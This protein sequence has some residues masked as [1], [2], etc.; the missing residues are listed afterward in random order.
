MML[1]SVLALAAIAQVLSSNTNECLRLAPS[2]ATNCAGGATP[3]LLGPCCLSL[4]SF[5]RG[6]C[7]CNKLTPKASLYAP[8]DITTCKLAEPPCV[9]YETR[10]YSG[11]TCAFSD[12]D[13]DFGRVGSIG[14]F[15]G[16]IGAYSTQPAT[17]CFDYKAFDQTIRGIFAKDG[18][19]A[20]AYGTGFF[21]GPALI[22]YI[23]GGIPALTKGL[24]AVLPTP[25]P[26]QSSE[27]ISISPGGSTIVFGQGAAASYV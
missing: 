13:I 1:Y 16:T 19:I 4:G 20:V 10:T 9:N 24:F 2:V 18:R 14:S 17:Q 7:H 12:M 3:D 22:Q 21:K 26:G 23:S 6:G 5:V 27:F 25:I 8:A 11:G 15:Y